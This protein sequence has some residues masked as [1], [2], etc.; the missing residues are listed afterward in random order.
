MVEISVI[1]PIYN[2]EF[3]IKRSINSIIDQTFQNWELILVDDGST[4]GSRLICNFYVS[5]DE[6]IKLIT[7]KNSGSGVAR[8]NGIQHSSG[9]YICFVDPDDFVDSN[10]LDHNLKLMK[11]YN[12]DLVVNG[13][14]DYTK[15][16]RGNIKISERKLGA[17]GF[18]NQ[19]KFRDEFYKYEKTGAK[20]L[21][22]KLYKRQFLKSNGIK[23][24][25][26]RVGQDVLFNYSVYRVVEN[27]YLDNNTF[28]YYDQTR[29][30]SAVKKYSDEKFLYEMNIAHSYH[31]MIK[32]WNKMDSY[33]Q[34]IMF[35]YWLPV[36][37]ELLNVNK[38]TSPLKFKDA[39]ARMVFIRNNVEIDNMFK[40][41][42]LR[43]VTGKFTKILY[44]L[45]KYRLTNIAVIFMKLYNQLYSKY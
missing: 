6:R 30:G 23:F 7:Q 40:K 5:Q 20:A 17:N 27:I 11:Q 44:L 19:E 28:Y 35:S 41:I 9:K 43:T 36:F 21:W 31:E 2:V 34:N 24:T 15:D 33:S 25:D 10:M 12:P 22:N 1:M 8:Q 13:Y 32:Y 4:D 29:D 37:N 18:Y 42:E 26:Q 38:K 3:F 16:I 14:F 39:V 45:M